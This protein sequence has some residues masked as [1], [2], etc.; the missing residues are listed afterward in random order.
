ASGIDLVLLVVA[1]D[2]SIRPQTLEHFH[3]CRLLGLTRGVVALS[4]VDLADADL[5]EIAAAEV[6]DLARGSFLEGGEIVPVS[7]RT[8]E[9]MPR[10]VEALRAAAKALPARDDSGDARL[11]VDRSFTVRGF[12]TVVTGTLVGGAVRSG[13]ELEVLTAGRRV[14]VRGIEVHGSAV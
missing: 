14:K 10:L 12:G 3:I 5:V 4:K 7:A 9:G 2:E 6:R 8:G 1:A 13:E 11:P